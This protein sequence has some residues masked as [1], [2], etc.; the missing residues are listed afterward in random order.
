MKTIKNLLVIGIAAVT[1]AVGF[2]ATT[3]KAADPQYLRGLFTNTT[4][5]TAY[6]PDTAATNYNTVTNNTRYAATTAK[7]VY[8]GSW[9]GKPVSFDIAAT[10]GSGGTN[11]WVQYQIALSDDNVYWISNAI[12]GLTNSLIAGVTNY[13]R[14]TVT[15]A[16]NYAYARWDYVQANQTN[17][18]V[19]VV[20]F[21]WQVVQ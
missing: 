1:L 19:Q 6:F 3:A 14:V 10:V 15:N 9:Q 17:S 5:G 11:G 7:S 12:P 21:G 2:H 13:N 18:T 20:K 4:F 8:I 16:P